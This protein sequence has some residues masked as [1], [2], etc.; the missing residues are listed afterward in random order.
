L[1]Q[2]YLDRTGRKLDELGLP[3]EIH[4]HVTERAEFVAS[5]SGDLI[6][7]AGG[8]SAQE[9]SPDELGGR[10]GRHTPDFD[11]LWEDMTGQYRAHPGAT[12]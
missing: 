11:R 3:T 7:D 4:A 2:R 10:R 8:D 5:S 1:R 9:S 6:A 12:W